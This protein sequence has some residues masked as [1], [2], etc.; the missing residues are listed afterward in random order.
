MEK[1]SYCVQRI[2]RVE[3]DATLENRQVRPGE[4]VTACQ[5]ACPTGAI[6]FGSLS[7]K[8][9]EMVRRRNEPRSYQVLHDTGTKPRTMYLARIDNPNPELAGEHE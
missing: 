4:V 1:C 6:Q 5:Q 7:H 3:I 9:T 8:D 2:R